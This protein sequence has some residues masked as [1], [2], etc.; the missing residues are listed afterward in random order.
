M[1]NVVINGGQSS[2][3]IRNVV[4]TITSPT[5]PFVYASEVAAPN[6]TTDIGSNWINTEGANPF[7]MN[8]VLS[9]VTTSPT[10]HKTVYVQFATDA[11]GTGYLSANAV[12]DSIDLYENIRLPVITYPANGAEVTS[13]N[14]VVQGTA[15][16]GATITVKVEALN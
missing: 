1:A 16:A 15:E 8:F 12:S 10:R 14:I 13:R 11:A 3:N 5:H 9:P 7:T 4:L 2:T 6:N